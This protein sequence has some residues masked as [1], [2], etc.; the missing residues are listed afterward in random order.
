MIQSS[1]LSFDLAES[2]KGMSS[3][4]PRIEKVNVYLCRF[5]VTGL[6][7]STWR[8]SESK[9]LVYE[10]VSEGSIGW[11]ESTAKYG[12]TAV[13]CRK[14]KKLLGKSPL[15]GEAVFD[16]KL[17][18]RTWLYDWYVGVDR[19]VR[20]IREGYSMALWDLAGKIQR[21]SFYDLSGRERKRDAVEGMPVIH[22]QEPRTMARIAET[23]VREGFK[24]FKVKLK[25]ESKRDIE[26]VRC[27]LGVS[28]DIQIFIVDANYGYK[29]EAD[30]IEAGQELSRMGVRYF[31]NPIKRP[32]SFYAALSARMN[33]PFTCD[34]TAYWPKVKS[35]LARNAA[36]LVNLHPN[37]MGGIDLLYRVVDFAGTQGIASIVGSSGHCGIQDK[38]FQ[39][40]AFTLNGEL[41]SE[42]VGLNAYYS[43]SRQEF[44]KCNYGYPSILKNDLK[45]HAGK[46]LDSDEEGFGIDV[47]R[48]RLEKMIEKKWTYSLS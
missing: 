37:C 34:N 23:W 12:A 3:N 42:E 7:Y 33:I 45:I 14:A 5:S 44:Y 18:S 46:I 26:A 32:L 9:F 47:D 13:A 35:V 41:P 30:L 4:S 6:N 36:Q 1:N 48:D 25:G 22:V 11:G 15:R 10:L 20:Q 40:V 31:Q 39:K 17:I 28:P 27:I 43:E 21:K 19:R 8:L 16:P 24:V 2:F 29:E 38:C